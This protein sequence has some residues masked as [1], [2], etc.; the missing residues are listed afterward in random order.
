[1]SRLPPVSRNEL[2]ADVQRLY[3]VIAGTRRDGLAGP[4]SAL[5]RNPIIA[6]PANDLHN[7]FRLKGK[8]D[9]RLFELVVLQVA[10]EWSTQYAW[11]VHERLAIKAGL[12]SSI[13]EAI[14]TDAE[15]VSMRDDERLIYL[16]VREILQHKT[17]GP[18]TYHKAAAALG[19]E[20]LIEVVAAVGF[21]SM[22]CWVLN[23]FD[24]PVR[25]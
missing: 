12:S 5:I 25:D 8:L 9:R 21:Y 2:T 7:A 18:A 6:E 3:D 15:P 23:V 13:I 19:L 22:L 11:S 17:L 1:M 24:I 10:H 20:L 16:L 14:R 4:F